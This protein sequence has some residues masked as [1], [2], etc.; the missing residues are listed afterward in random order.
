M[1][2]KSNTLIID[3]KTVDCFIY[4][5]KDGFLARLAHDLKLRVKRFQIVI[6]KEQGKTPQS[7]MKI[8]SR[9]VFDTTSIQSV[10]AMKDGIEMPSIL[11]PWD[12]ALVEKFMRLYVLRSE[13][14]PEIAFESTGFSMDSNRLRTKGV[15]T[16]CGMSRP[17]SLTKKRR[18]RKMF[19]GETVLHQPDFGIKPFSTLMGA[20]KIKPEVR[21]ELQIPQKQLKRLSSSNPE[22]FPRGL[23]AV[24]KMIKDLCSSPPVHKKKRTVVVNKR[25]LESFLVPALGSL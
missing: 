16:L 21:I 13:V 1:G 18:T 15:L 2:V 23:S 14:F 8:N 24:R 12:H 22:F 9:A 7:R 4:T 11:K 20:M 19:V 25:P 3:S 17:I 6:R 5:Y 10:T